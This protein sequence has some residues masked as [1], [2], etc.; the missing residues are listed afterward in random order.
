MKLNYISTISYENAY[1]DKRLIYRENKN[2]CG[3]YC[4]NNKI[5][6]EK[7][8]G[9]SLCLNKRFYTYFSSRCLEEKLTKGNSAI[10]SAL[11]KYGYSNFSLDIIEYCEPSILRY[12]EQYYIN[13]LE[14]EY[15][16][17]KQVSSYLGPK[18]NRNIK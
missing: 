7:Y 15:N 12:R 9:S 3:I 2:K 8:I 16:M 6:F 1:I 11:L 13:F 18:Q 4:W 5:T 17:L 10:Y 14:P